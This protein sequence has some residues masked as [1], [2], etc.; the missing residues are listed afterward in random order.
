MT[1]TCSTV[2]KRHLCPRL[3]LMK[4]RGAMSR[5]FSALRRPC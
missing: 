3:P 4:V 1:I 5:H 2:M